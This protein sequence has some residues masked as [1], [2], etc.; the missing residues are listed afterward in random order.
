[1]RQQ[2]P[3]EELHNECTLPAISIAIA[4]DVLRSGV[5][6]LAEATPVKMLVKAIEASH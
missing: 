1:M 3:V 4:V 6:T 2:R 5:G